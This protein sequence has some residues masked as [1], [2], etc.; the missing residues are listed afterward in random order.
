M[1][2]VAALRPEIAA[3][4]LVALFCSSSLA[5][6]DTVPGLGSLPI[7]RFSLD[8]T[9]VRVVFFA[10][11]EPPLRGTVPPVME[12]DQV[13]LF[14]VDGTGEAWTIAV[15]ARAQRDGTGRETAAGRMRAEGYMVDLSPTTN[16]NQ[17]ADERASVRR[18]PVRDEPVEGLEHY[19]SPPTSYSYFVGDDT[20]AF[21]SA[22]CS[23]PPRAVYL[24]SYRMPI[25]EG[26]VASVSFVDFRLHGGR[27]EA[28]RRLRFAREVIC[29]YL[30]RC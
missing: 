30:E 12:T 28:N 19:R 22:Q 20:D 10:N 5:G 29:R 27:A 4:S 25:T 9:P 24:C 7:Y 2:W 13:G 15:E 18:R 17:A 23:S 14:F 21:W 1:T 3:A 6:A 11:T 16:R 26:V 8:S